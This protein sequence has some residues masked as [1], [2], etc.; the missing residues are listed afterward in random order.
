MQLWKK[1]EEEYGFKNK[2]LITI[3]CKIIEIREVQ[4]SIDNRN[5]NYDKI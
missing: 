5:R 2:E 4:R 3:P 1:A